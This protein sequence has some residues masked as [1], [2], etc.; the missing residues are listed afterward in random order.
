MI[1]SQRYATK[2]W[3]NMMSGVTNLAIFAM[4]K[5]QAAKT[6]SSEDSSNPQISSK[7]PT[8]LRTLKKEIRRYKIILLPIYCVYCN[9]I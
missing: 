7:P 4:A 8:K 2:Y 9:N 5:Q 1:A 6:P 3:V